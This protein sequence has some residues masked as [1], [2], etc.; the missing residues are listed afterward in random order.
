MCNMSHVTYVIFKNTVTLVSCALPCRLME[1]LFR[2]IPGV[3]L[4]GLR[5]D[6]FTFTLLLVPPRIL[7]EQTCNGRQQR[8]RIE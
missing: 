1:G 4:L 6:P 5:Q 7:E 8:I 2:L 3:F